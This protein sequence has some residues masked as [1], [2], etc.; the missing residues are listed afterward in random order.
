MFKCCCSVLHLHVPIIHIFL[1]IR[2]IQVAFGRQVQ[3]Q[4][5]RKDDTD[6][7]HCPIYHQMVIIL[8]KTRLETITCLLLF[9]TCSL[10]KCKRTID[11][12]NV[13]TVPTCMRISEHSQ[14]VLEHN[15]TKKLFF[16]R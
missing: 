11:H 14:Y 6:A 5:C 7:S 12:T 9:A 13:P 4:R 2:I 16:A 3:T 1:H 10:K 15:R 8:N